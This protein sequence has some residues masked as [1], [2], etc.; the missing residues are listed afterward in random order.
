[1][2][3]AAKI[4]PFWF[5]ANYFYNLSLV[6][7]SITSSTVLASTG[8]V[9]T[10][11]LAVYMTRTE[12][13]SSF[14][15]IGVLLAVLGSAWTSFLDMFHQSISYSWGD[16]IGLIAAVG[17]GIY[18]ILLSHLC[19]KDETLMSMNLLLGY[20]GLFH[21]VFWSPGLLLFFL[22]APWSPSGT[23]TGSSGPLSASIL[24]CLIGKGFLDNVLSDYLWARSVLLTSAT[25]ATVGLGLTIPLAFV[26]DWI[27][28]PWA[29]RNNTSI[30]A[31]TSGEEEWK[32]E[33][34]VV[35]EQNIMGAILVLVGFILVNIGHDRMIDDQRNE[36]EAEDRDEDVDEEEN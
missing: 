10:Y 7:T 33:D 36:I 35:N 14:K 6:M 31:T 5:L 12:K 1:M 24:A 16:A 34:T 21:L 23:G 19:P 11:L 2:I 20:M 17:Y 9:F 18:T 32:Q 26:S 4:A 13:A 28:L 30:N 15:F 22:Q 8:S 3:T 25:V 27:L 29:Q